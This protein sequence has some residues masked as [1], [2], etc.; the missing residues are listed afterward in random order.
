ML[1]SIKINC[2]SISKN[3]LESEL[4]GYEKGSFT[5]ADKNGKIG[6][7]KLQMEALFF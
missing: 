1:P 7:L 6:F 4:F 3:L 5:G 2:G